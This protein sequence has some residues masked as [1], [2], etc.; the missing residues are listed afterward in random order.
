[1]KANVYE[2][3]SSC[4]YIVALRARQEA[5]LL[6]DR[7]AYR[8]RVWLVVAAMVAAAVVWGSM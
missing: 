5:E 4:S 3:P 2:V 7:L 1:M 8:R 6:V